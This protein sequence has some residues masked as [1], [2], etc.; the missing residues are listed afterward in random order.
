MADRYYS[1]RLAG[2][3]PRED[4]TISAA[5]WRGFVAFVKSRARDGWFAERYP[6]HCF[7]T[8]LPVETALDAL[9]AA[10][11]AHNPRVPWPLDAHTP[12]ALLDVLDSVEFFARIVSI[13]THRVYHD[14][15]RHNHITA[16]DRDQGFV[17]FQTEISKC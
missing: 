10:F 6:V 12:P 9:G 14:Y 5:F 13:P 1:E 4:Q 8:P 3:A 17:E 11:A 15:G 2:D 7:E 16:F